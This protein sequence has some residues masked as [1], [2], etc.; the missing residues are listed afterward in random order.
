MII[1]EKAFAITG[2]NRGIGL[3]VAKMAAAEK[4]KL[5]LVIRKPDAELV[6]YLEKMGASSIKV[7]ISDL[8]SP[9]DTK[10]LIEKLIPEK[11]DILFNNAGVLTGGLLEEQTADEIDQ[12]F[13]INV[14]SL[15]QLTRGLLPGMIQRNCGKIINNSSVSAIMHFPCATTYAASKAAVMAFTDCLQAELQSTG[16]STLCLITPGIKTRMFDEI[17]VK[18]SKNLK[19]PTD[20]ITPDEYALRIKKA[21]QSDQT[22][23]FPKGATAIG[24]WIA[25]H[26]TSLFNKAVQ[27][28]FT[29]NKRP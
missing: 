8:S 24:L 12:I 15:V 14:T 16:V 19:T 27:S 5:H 29:R 2:A 3:A 1:S 23:L 21:I 9:E 7:W 6:S 20:W 10:N 11:I 4:A 25:R 26:W 28:R 17:D 22:Y 13:Q 18:Y